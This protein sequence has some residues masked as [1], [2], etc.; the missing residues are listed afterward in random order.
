MAD[1]HAR[2][3][4]LSSRGAIRAAVGAAVVIAGLGVM[5]TPAH[6]HTLVGCDTAGLISAVA[7]ANSSGGGTLDLSTG[8]TYT[9]ESGPYSTGFGS[10]GLPVITTAIT[11]HGNGAT[12]TRDPSAPAFRLIETA[13]GALTADHITLSQGSEVNG[14]GA[15]A[16]GTSSPGTLTLTDATIANNVAPEFNGGG[17]LNSAGTATVTNTTFAGNSAFN[18][19]GI[20]NEATLTLTNVTFSGNSAAGCCPG[21]GGGIFKDGGTVTLTNSTLANN[22]GADC[23]LLSPVTDGGYNLDGDGSCG[24]TA[25]SDKNNVD[26]QLGPLQGN[27]GPTPTMALASTSPAID[28]IPAGTNGCGTA[29]STDQRG[30]PRPQG[31]GCDMGAYESGDVAMQSLTAN[32]NP[33]P[34]LSKLT[35]TATVVNAGAVDATGVS[36]TDTLPAGEKYKSATAS[37]GSCSVLAQ[38]VT[39]N[40][41]QVGAATTATVTIVVKV[42]AA[43]GSMLT[44]T[45]TVSAT[46]GDTIPGNDSKTRSV[47]VS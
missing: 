24:L 43:S 44:D 17:I 28:A 26:P 5:S 18:G 11:I 6:A 22:S 16:N 25:A 41:G 38:K 33:V 20:L 47:T 31:A 39:C 10:D 37:Q 23:G 34:S 13:N 14:G 36:V 21:H 46:T 32:H 7:S 2:I 8:C 35:Y 3:S 12:I 42:K 9:L 30:V 27:G 19:G 1:R 4:V 29:I 40:L 45:A 15:I